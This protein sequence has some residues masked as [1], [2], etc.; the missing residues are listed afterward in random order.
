MKP[1]EFSLR[2][3][4]TKSSCYDLG[5]LIQS[6]NKMNAKEQTTRPTRTGSPRGTYDLLP[7]ESNDWNEVEAQARTLLFRAGFNE[8]RTPIFEA[9]EIFQRAAG[10]ASDIVNKEMY[11]FLDRSERSLTLRP[12]GTAGVVRAY[13][14][15]GLDRKPKP[16]KLWYLGPMFR[17]E[18]AQT[19]R[20]RQFT[21]LGV[22]VFGSASAEIEFECIHLAW[23]LLSNLGTAN[24]TLEVNSVGDF[25][26]RSI[27]QSAMKKFLEENQAVICPDCLNRMN[28]NPLR[29]LDCKVPADQALYSKG[30]PKIQDYLSEDCKAH[31]ERLLTSLKRANIPY[32]L[33]RSL[34]RGLD[35][36]TK[37]V[38]E[39]K[40]TDSRLGTQNTICAGGRYDGLVRE[41]GGPETPA[42]GWALGMERLM[43]LLPQQ[44]RDGQTDFFVVYQPEEISFSEA[45]EVVAQVRSRQ[46]TVLIDY[47]NRSLAKQIELANKSGANCVLQINKKDKSRT[48]KLCS[49][50]VHLDSPQAVEY[51]ESSG[52]ASPLN[53]VSHNGDDLWADLGKYC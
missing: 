41:F 42:F 12:E 26:S 24:L 22:E 7:P 53:F 30:A 49:K 17:Y 37:T 14:S 31:Q 6:Q 29:A 13:L 9:T 4:G 28:T 25:E 21:Q 52:N 50:G 3:V 38:F 8:I 46:A 27:Y 45:F 48:I 34:V 35:Y 18:R 36:Y 43:A 20:Y 15:N 5:L 10:E 33:N 1:R 23:T 2:Q 32:S 40:T 39:I 44:P 19:G 51:V 11:T 16:V 47:E